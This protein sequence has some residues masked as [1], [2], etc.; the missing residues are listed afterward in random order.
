V[1]PGEYPVGIES[2]LAGHELSELKIVMKRNCAGSY[3]HENFLTLQKYINC[4]FSGGFIC[5]INY[6]TMIEA[7]N[8]N[9][10]LIFN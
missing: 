4:L 7:S 3:C 6:F 5:S 9:D 10:Y 1:K 2:V 8:Y